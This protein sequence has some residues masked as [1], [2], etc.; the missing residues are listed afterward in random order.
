MEL[1]YGVEGHDPTLNPN[2]PQG[3]FK[4]DYPREGGGIIIP[5]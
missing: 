5:P 1:G 2:H 3:S 4:K